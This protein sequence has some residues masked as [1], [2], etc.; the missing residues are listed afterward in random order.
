MTRLGTVP[1]S[2]LFEM[3]SWNLLAGNGGVGVGAAENI[4]SR[5]KFVDLSSASAPQHLLQHQGLNFG[6]IY[7]FPR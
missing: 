6:R 1:C 5:E 7:R 3:L 2:D 4:W